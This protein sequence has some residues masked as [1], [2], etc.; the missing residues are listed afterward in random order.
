MLNIPLRWIKII[1]YL[2]LYFYPSL[3]YSQVIDTF[4]D[5]RDGEVYKIVQIEK[6]WWF[7]ENL[8]Y[9]SN[10]SHCPNFNKKEKDCIAGNFYPNTE[11]ETVCPKGWHVATLKE[12]E[13]YFNSRLLINS[14]ANTL[15]TETYLPIVDILISDTTKQIQLFDK[16]NLLDLHPHGWVQGR[17]RQDIGTM[18]LWAKNKELKDNKYHIHIGNN[19]YVKHTHKHHIEDKKVRRNRKF[20]VR[21]VC[22]K[23]PK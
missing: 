16:N 7:Q 9:E 20:M 12:W 21:C 2:N 1:L 4:L 17:K 19:S 11:L 23:L 6:D 3:F 14:A 18:T 13:N 22:Q 8:R 5:Y 15:E 10:Y